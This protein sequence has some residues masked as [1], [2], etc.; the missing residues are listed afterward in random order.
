MSDARTLPPDPNAKENREASKKIGVLSALWPFL[1]PYRLL[2]VA[3]MIALV[4]TAM[5]SLTLPIAVRR[6]IDG[7]DEKDPAILDQ[8]FLAALGIAALLARGTAMP[9]A[10]RKY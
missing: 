2:M 10:A 6:V 9:K 3:A 4:L 8:Y 7:F 5:V 1:K